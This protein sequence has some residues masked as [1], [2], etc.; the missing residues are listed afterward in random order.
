MHAGPNCVYINN[1]RAT[2][3]TIAT[4]SNNYIDQHEPAEKGAECQVSEHSSLGSE[5]SEG[6][7]AWGGTLLVDA[8]APGECLG[9]VTLSGCLCTQWT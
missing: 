7:S 1:C 5:V 2:I 6:L 4:T 9:W 3:T 8:H